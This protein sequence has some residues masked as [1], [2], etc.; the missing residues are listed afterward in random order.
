[1]ITAN[2]IIINAL[3]SSVRKTQAKVELYNGSTLVN[4]YYYNDRIKSFN[5]ERVGE[6][7]KF[8]GFGVCQKLNLHLIDKSR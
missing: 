8:F 4:T 3:N 6:E 7:S 1:M 5:I 2:E